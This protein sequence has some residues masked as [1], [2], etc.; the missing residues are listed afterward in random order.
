MVVFS[1]SIVSNRKILL[2]RQFVEMTRGDVETYL[3]RFIKKIEQF[4][5]S[6]EYTYMEIDNI[7][8]I[9]QAIDSIY[10]ILM[11]PLSSNIIEDMDSL[12]LF[13]QVLYDCCN[14]PPPITEELIADNCFEV[15][16][17][18]D[19]IISFGYKESI[20]LSQIKTCLEMES[21]EEKLHKMIRQNKENEEKERRRHIA[22]KLDKERSSNETFG[23]S[24][25]IP[26]TS[27][28]NIVKSSLSGIAAFAESVGV[29]KIAKSV[30]IGPIKNAIRGDNPGMSSH[31][32][33]SANCKS[34]GKF[35]S[36]S[37]S[38]QPINAPGKGMLLGKK[39]P[40]TEF[41]Q[42]TD[43]SSSIGE[44]SYVDT[45]L[46]DNIGNEVD[47][48]HFEDDSSVI[49]EKIEFM[50]NLDGTI[51]SKIEI[52][53]TF[54]ITLSSEAFPEYSITE[55]PRFQF[56]THPNL[57]KEKFQ[58]YGKLI[59]KEGISRTL[60]INTLMPLVKWRP[61]TKFQNCP[62]EIPFS[63]S[64]WPIDSGD[65]LTNITIEIEPQQLITDFILKIP[66]T[67]ISTYNVNVGLF[68]QIEGN[69][70]WNAP[71]LSPSE[72]AVLELST[73]QPHFLPINICVSTSQ[74]VCKVGIMK[75]KCQVNPKC[76]ISKYNVVIDK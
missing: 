22:N 32:L 43:F 9:Y 59:L 68:E 30:G 10:L 60:P 11:T 24:N 5:L 28:N 15:I 71:Q 39:K 47:I 12:Q 2:S 75:D 27:N 34:F 52:Q 21:Q 4:C 53:G 25:Y 31:D 46:Q 37:S 64:C 40:N 20:N 67:S 41:K 56:K 18:F 49:E 38:A 74:S 36:E 76:S 33:L 66:V 69:Y 54:Q 58:K 1:A 70:H 50:L 61:S 44:K 42:N 6:N 51:Q 62:F 3:N 26:T 7:R 35:A 14:N 48:A 55:D 73:N 29:G 23:Q 65:G 8:F 19:E 57:D 13:C 45:K 63:F 17:A 16:F 72:T